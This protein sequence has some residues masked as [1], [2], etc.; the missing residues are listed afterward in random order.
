MTPGRESGAFGVTPA[1]EVGRIRDTL[2][3]PAEANLGATAVGTVIT[4]DRERL[5]RGAAGAVG[6]VTALA[7]RI[8]HEAATE[9][10]RDASRTGADVVD[11]VVARGPLDPE[12]A[13]RL[14]A[15]AG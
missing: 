12:S 11:V 8:G 9:V 7:A 10:A 15:A 5:A 13:P 3:L 14:I 2:P 1:E 6:A 4:A